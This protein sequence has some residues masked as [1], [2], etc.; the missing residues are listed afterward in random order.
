L[1]LAKKYTISVENPIYQVLSKEKRLYY[2]RDFPYDIL[3]PVSRQFLGLGQFELIIPIAT[4]NNLYAIV[5]LGHQKKE[6]QFHP[7]DLEY[8]SLLGDLFSSAYVHI[9]NNQQF[10]IDKKML[11]KQKEITDMIFKFS[12]EIS[13][14][15]NLDEIYDALKDTLLNTF[16]IEAFSLILLD[17]TDDCYKIFAGNIISP[18]SIEKFRLNIHSNLINI[19]KNSP[20]IYE[21]KDFNDSQDIIHNYSQE[22]LSIFNEYI[23]I[24]LIS[25]SW[26]IGFITIHKRGE[27]WDEIE[28]NKILYLAQISAPH[29]A[30]ALILRTK[31]QMLAGN[32]SPIEK[33]MEM[34]LFTAKHS[35]A[36][37]SFA[38]LK[39]KNIKRMENIVHPKGFDRFINNIEK[40]F[41]KDLSPED[42]HTKL[43]PGL[44]LFILRGKNKKM[45]NK[46][47][48]KKQKDINKVPIRESLVSPRISY[49]ILSYPDDGDDVKKYLSILN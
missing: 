27:N 36:N 16:S 26:L 6:Q 43:L 19:L 12:Q 40:I 30:N 14:I 33:R 23:I 34:E 32:F 37:L 25:A 41:L 11:E 48:A 17:E 44:Y 47:M 4:E 21:I 3:D 46:Y 35:H 29:I 10:V 20:D 45:A 28:Q 13:Q 18:Q 42:Y 38:I 5:F 8:L 2:T 1:T 22:D 9:I 7:D 24:P 31:N 15:S 39:H 49:N